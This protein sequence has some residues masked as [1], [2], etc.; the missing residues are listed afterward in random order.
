MKQKSRKA[1]GRRLQNY[2]RDKILKT[3]RHLKT[4]DV[5]CVENYGPGTNIL[6]SKVAATLVAH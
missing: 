6:L 4:K 5:V 1:K 3:F 2:V